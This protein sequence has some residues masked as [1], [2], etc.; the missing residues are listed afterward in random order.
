MPNNNN[1]TRQGQSGRALLNRLLQKAE[2]PTLPSVAQKL[3]ELCKDENATFAHFAQVIETDPGLA[4]RILKVT[5]SAYY[6][7][8]NKATTLKRAIAVL[9]LKYVKTVSLGFHVASALNKFS[10]DG[11]DMREFWQQSV[12]RGVI[13]R[14]LAASYCPDGYEE[15]FLIG[16]LQDCGVPFLVQ[17]Q[18]EMYAQM[19]HQCQG[20]QASLF[21]LEQEVFEFDHLTAAAALAEQWSLPE[22]LARPIRTHHRRPQATASKDEQ[23]QLCQISYFVGTLSMNNPAA[24]SEEDW[25]LPQFCRDVFNL[26]ENKLKKLL[27][28]SRKEFKNIAQL[29]TEILPDQ[30]EVTELLT[31]AKDLLSGLTSEDPHTTFSL[32]EE[33]RRLQTRCQDLSESVDE[34]QQQAETDAMTGLDQRGPLGRFLDNGCWQ[35]QNNET[36]MAVMFLDVD[37]FKDINN[38]HSH[39][40]GDRLLKELAQLLRNTFNNKACVSRYGGDEFVVALLGLDIQQAIQQTRKLADRIHQIKIPVRSNDP[41]EQADFSCSI[42][43]LFCE[44]GARLG[45]SDRVLELADNQMYEVKN[46]GKDGVHYQIISAET[47]SVPK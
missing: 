12:L 44:S 3:V 31:Q 22:I 24:I 19:W 18:G 33:V 16:L 28:Q 42:G 41:S 25:H 8:R 21:Q 5:N 10:S 20:S 38:L 26:D 6:G 35:V 17:A 9:G 4:S 14:Q 15:A 45:N 27:T 46:S 2:V 34:Y 47:D 1:A 32:E 7:L 13:A 11:F 36:S 39:A 37:N 30:V 29:F 40:A 43:L 23:I